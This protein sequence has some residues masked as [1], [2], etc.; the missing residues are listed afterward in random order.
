MGA[1]ATPRRPP[2]THSPQGPQAQRIQTPARPISSAMIKWLGMTVDHYQVG[3]QLRRAEHAMALVFEAKLRP[4]EVT[5]SQAVVLLAIDRNP[6]A[7]MARVARSV[8]IT[9]HTFQRIVAGLERRGLVVRESRG[10]EQ[11][12][13]YLSL[14]S[15]GTQLLRRTEAILKAEQDVIREHFDAQELQTLYMLLQRFEAIFHTGQ[16]RAQE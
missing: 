2:G 3:Y 13:L 5:T 1:D 10:G 11:K 7:T 15:S 14:T 9:Q 6:D 12:S 8:A 4:L 16:E